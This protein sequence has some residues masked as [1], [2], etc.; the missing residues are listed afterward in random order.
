M[1]KQ[2]LR[3]IVHEPALFLCS[4]DESPSVSRNKLQRFTL[5]RLDLCRKH[6]NVFTCARLKLEAL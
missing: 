2:N 5:T 6:L 4:V 3:E 1:E